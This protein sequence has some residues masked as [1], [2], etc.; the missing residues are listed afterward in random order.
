MT[1][2]IRE[3][4]TADIS[5]LEAFFAG[6]PAE[7]RTF[8]KDDVT[9]SAVVGR[10]A[11]A[12]RFIRRVGT[13]DDAAIVAFAALVPGVERSGH[14]ADLR[15]VV[16]AGGRRRGLGTRLARNML[17]EAVTHG[18]TKVT[19]DIAADN[20]GAIHMFRGLG[21]QPEALLRDHL[22]DA[23][24]ELRDLVVLAHHVCEQW[25]IMQTVGIVEALG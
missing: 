8:F 18:F 5:D 13:V 7:D 2:V 17:V 15:L 14:V 25:E 1:E 9:D 10:L 3:M 20:P 19:I 4:T 12:D 22:R 6:V 16:A 24:G 23:D 11:S 21:F